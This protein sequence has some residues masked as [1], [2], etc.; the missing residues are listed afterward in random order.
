MATLAAGAAA[1]VVH[2][3][4]GGQMNQ[5]Q[6]KTAEKSCRCCGQQLRQAVKH[7]HGHGRGKGV[8]FLNLYCCYIKT[9]LKEAVVNSFAKHMHGHEREPQ[10]EMLM[11]LCLEHYP[12][13]YDEVVAWCENSGFTM[14]SAVKGDWF[15]G[16]S[17][18]LSQGDWFTVVRL[19]PEV[20]T[21]RLVHC[22]QVAA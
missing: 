7:K 15:T 6:A 14:D 1:S 4:G 20:V 16:C 12:E 21:R 8:F 2:G 5:A 19:Q 18:K 9:V 3:G 11:E 22:G 13:R 17:L 10:A